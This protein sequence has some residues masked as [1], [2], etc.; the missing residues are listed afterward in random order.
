MLTSLRGARGTPGV[1]V[2]AVA[3]VLAL[4]RPVHPAPPGA[5]SEYEIK[6]AFLYNFA[7]YVEWPKGALPD[8]RFV[9]GVIGTDPFG[10]ILGAWLHRV[11]ADETE[12][13]DT[14]REVRL[15]RASVGAADEHRVREPGAA[16]RDP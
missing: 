8:G 7:K 13:A 1:S 15:D 16:P 3:F 2:L 14:A 6:A 4:A 12:A 10:S 9:V 11:A 5:P